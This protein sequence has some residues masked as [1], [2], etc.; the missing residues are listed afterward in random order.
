MKPNP[1]KTTPPAGLSE[2]MLTWWN[3]LNEQF[4]LED[5]QLHLLRLAVFAYDRAIQAK[6]AL[7][8][9]G[10]FYLDKYGCPHPR[11]ET[12]IEKQ[13]RLDFARL[14]KQLGF[15][16]N[17]EPNPPGRRPGYSPK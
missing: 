7:D 8:K 16:E 6:Q 12:V 15:F 10:L 11:P 5:H 1:T 4:L 17:D 13:S 2:T 9:N 3:H 14:I